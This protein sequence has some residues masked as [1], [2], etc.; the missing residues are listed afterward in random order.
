L[1]EFNIVYIDCGRVCFS[2]YGECDV[3]RVGSITFHSPFLN[4]YWIAARLICSF[5]E[6]MAGSLS[7]VFSAWVPV[8]D[9]GE[10]AR[11]A[12]YCRY[13]N[14]PRTLPWGYACIDWGE[15]PQDSN[16]HFTM[17]NSP[18]KMSSMSVYTLT[19]VL[20]GTNTFGKMETTRN[21]PCLFF[22]NHISQKHL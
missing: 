16:P 14:G 13:N 7:V 20:P 10:V 22:I 3:D 19:G 1:G 4:Q 9:S 2:S 6:A 11:S 15:F 21:Y 18:K 12:A 17:C 5:C 8:V